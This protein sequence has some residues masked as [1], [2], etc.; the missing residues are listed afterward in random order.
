METT[1]TVGNPLE[2][3][4]LLRLTAGYT[5]TLMFRIFMATQEGI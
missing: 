1:E 5:P 4:Q 3:L 2:A